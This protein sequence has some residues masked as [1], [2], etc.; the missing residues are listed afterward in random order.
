MKKEEYIDPFSNESEM[1]AKRLDDATIS[2]D[3]EKLETLLNEIEIAL[4]NTDVISQSR[5]Y[6]SIGTV[7]RDFAKAKYNTSVSVTTR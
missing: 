3:I 7:Y 4:P 2:G 1:Y 6:Y 5:L